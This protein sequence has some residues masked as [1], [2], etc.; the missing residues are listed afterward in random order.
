MAALAASDI[1]AIAARHPSVFRRPLRQRLAMPLLA[2]GLVLYFVYAVWFFAIPQV[3]GGA[4]WERAGAY[5]S[6]WVSYEVRPDI[7]TKEVHGACR[8]PS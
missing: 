1:E 3:L 4:R 8:A 5:L 7:R 6:D 2:L